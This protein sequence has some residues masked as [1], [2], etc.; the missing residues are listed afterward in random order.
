M[1]SF[2][3]EDA[4]R[5]FCICLV[6]SAVLRILRTT[7]CRSERLS[8]CCRY[9]HRRSVHDEKIIR[10]WVFDT[11]RIWRPH[12]RRNWCRISSFT[13]VV[14]NPL[15]AAGDCSI[16]VHSRFRPPSCHR[17]NRCDAVTHSDII[18][19]RRETFDVAFLRSADVAGDRSEEI[20]IVRTQ[21][22]IDSLIGVIVVPDPTMIGSAAE[23]G[24]AG[25]GPPLEP[26]A[27][28][29]TFGFTDPLTVAPAPVTD[30]AAFVVTVGA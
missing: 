4:E 7:P 8:S 30:V 24:Q 26:G 19:A 25:I 6:G 22:E 11:Y 27:R 13:I 3:R 10:R 18:R 9:T 23:G 1:A 5:I 20:N 17:A 16:P 29:L 12:H 14:G 28:R 15:E 21:S 2:R